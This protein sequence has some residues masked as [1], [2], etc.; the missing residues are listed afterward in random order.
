MAQIRSTPSPKLELFTVFAGVARA[1]GNPH[2]LDLLEQLSQGEKAVEALASKADLSFANASQHLRVLHR[3]GLVTADRRG[4]Q[5]VYRLASQDV[6]DLLA[7][8][9]QVAERHADGAQR[10]VDDYFRSRDRL[11]PVGFDELERKMA[12]GLVTVLDVRPGDEFVQ[13]HLPGALNIP[14]AEL[15]S[16]LGGLP[17][18]RD[19]VAYCRGPWCVLA[20]E[21]VA[22]LRAAG[23]TAHRLDGGLPEWRRSGRPVIAAA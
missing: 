14:L 11:H 19:V 1:L 12:D 15:Q 13:G 8:L 20:F 9:R 23:R 2:R 21:A 22:L 4:K 10:V 5:V 18:E 3:A 17:L 16:R 6:H 7:A